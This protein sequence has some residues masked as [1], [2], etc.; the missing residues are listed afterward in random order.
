MDGD[1]EKALEAGC[2]DYISKPIKKAVL[3]EKIKTYL[4]K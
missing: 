2:D 1:R 3:L 4:L